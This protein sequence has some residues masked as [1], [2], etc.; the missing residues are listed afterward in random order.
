MCV[1]ID[2]VN[3]LTSPTQIY[4]KHTRIVLFRLPT[5]VPPLVVVVLISLSSLL[6]QLRF[7]W[8]LLP[9]KKKDLWPATTRCRYNSSLS[10]SMDR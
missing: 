9:Y 4:I 2:I 10:L 1:G 6:L 5:L 7:A 3:R 8:L